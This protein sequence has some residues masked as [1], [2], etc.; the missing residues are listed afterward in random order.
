M[1]V[2][3]D[4]TKKQAFEEAM[5]SSNVMESVNE[6]STRALER[7]NFERIKPQFESPK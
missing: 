6:A 2:L 4:S 7:L 1:V 5:R 3:D